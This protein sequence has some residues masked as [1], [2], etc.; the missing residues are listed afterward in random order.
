MHPQPQTGHFSF[1]GNLSVGSPSAA[2][3]FVDNS[4]GRVGI[5]TYSPTSLLY[6]AGA[7][8][9]TGNL[10][11]AD[12]SVN[13]PGLSFGNENGTGIYRTATQ[14]YSI[15][16]LGS[17][18]LRIV[19]PGTSFVD[20]RNRLYL[21]GIGPDGGGW[22]DTQASNVRFSMTGSDSALY[23]N[24]SGAAIVTISTL[25]DNPLRFASASGT[26]QYSEPATGTGDFFIETDSDSFVGVGTAIPNGTLHVYVPNNANALVVNDTTG[27]VG[28]G[29]RSPAY[30]LE[31]RNTAA[32]GLAANISDVLY[33]NSSSRSVGIEAPLPAG[34]YILEAPKSA[35]LNGTL[36][37][38]KG[39]VGIGTNSTP[40]RLTVAGNMGA[41]ESPAFGTVTQVNTTFPPGIGGGIGH[42]F[43]LAIGSDGLPVI[44]FN[45]NNNNLQ[46]LH[47]GSS[48]C[49]STGN[50]ITTVD[51]IGNIQANPVMAI[52]TDGLPIIVYLED[53]PGYNFKV[54]KCGN[55]ACSEGNN[56]TTVVSGNPSAGNRDIAIGSDGLPVI[57]YLNSSDGDIHVLKCG[58]A[59]CSVGNTEAN[60]DS[61][62]NIG[63]F[64]HMAIAPDGM[65]IIS[66]ADG[67]NRGLRVAKCGNIN[68]S[69]SNTLTTLAASGTDTDVA[70]FNSIAIGSDGLPIIAYAND[71]TN[72]LI[73]IKCGNAACST[74]N[75]NFTV[76][77][78]GNIGGNI[79]RHNSI[80]I[81]MDGLPIIS[82]YNQSNGTLKVVKCGNL[83][84]SAGNTITTVDAENNTGRFTSI[85]VDAD[86]LPII[87][88]SDVTRGKMKVLKCANTACSALSG[89]SFSGG[90][91]LGSWKPNE[92]S[93]GVPYRAVSTLAVS[94][95][96]TFTN[97]SFLVN[98]VERMT[99]TPYGDIG[100]GTQAPSAKLH[101]SGAASTGL[102]L[103]VS[104]VLYV[105]H[106]NGRIGIAT[107]TPSYTLELKDT[108]ANGLTA[109]ISNTLY[110]NATTGNVGI[111][112]TTP[113]QA[114]H[115]AGSV[116]MT[117]N[118]SLRAPNGA[119][120]TCGVD[121]NAVFRC[122]A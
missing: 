10:S 4:S 53:A 113:N 100:I 40:F 120:Y 64:I 2:R 48:N 58:N 114:L 11:I 105:N 102:A 93:Y 79:G 20:F 5:G 38:I 45:G 119:V 75:T 66:Y 31:V 42:P 35:A 29:T 97:L 87:A 27:Y 86:G 85:V 94:N 121:N 115:V 95:P 59:A 98:G 14:D 107:M 25:T 36:F 39:S 19:A 84:C 44:A 13:S 41:N 104:G 69:A 3:L 54:V 61:T 30:Q 46:V 26:G 68:C 96:T 17:Q 82:Y 7:M 62:G 47:C 78:I 118:I 22:I 81:G 8:N 56:V 23:L 15:S 90:S 43:S 109:N 1:S 9:V 24:G 106:T 60:V 91:M 34:N 18:I 33:V 103:N 50:N 21:N 52:G 37:A 73:L 51:A 80:A 65:P 32:N 12:G 57:A 74:G 77:G 49:N 117:G 111:N 122:S 110:V 108:A 63:Q 83:N 67:A 28:I 88:Y 99:I 116:N 89:T 55:V 16:R 76:D 112:T 92:R 72:S 101:I 70:A 71:T 6:V